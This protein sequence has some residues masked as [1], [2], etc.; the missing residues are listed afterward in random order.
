MQWQESQHL[1]LDLEIVQWNSNMI[2]NTEKV[3][4]KR[5]IK[6]WGLWPCLIHPIILDAPQT[7]DP[8]HRGT[9]F[10]NICWIKSKHK[11]LHLSRALQILI[12]SEGFSWRIPLQK[13]LYSWFLYKLLIL[14]SCNYYY[15]CVVF[16]YSLS[17]LCVSVCTHTHIRTCA[18]VLLQ[19]NW[20]QLLQVFSGRS[21]ISSVLNF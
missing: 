21:L 2:Q 3:R 10:T 5:N 8:A 20:I 13:A 1:S 17:N 7:E 18:S 15:S 16:N 14:P 11:I 12:T 9:Y 6:T 19:E 4:V